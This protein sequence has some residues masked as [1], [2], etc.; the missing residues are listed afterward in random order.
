M[1]A[2]RE[3]HAPL[4]IKSRLLLD[5]T[6][7]NM[8]SPSH[9]RSLSISISNCE[10]LVLPPTTDFILHYPL[11]PSKQVLHLSIAADQPLER[12]EQGWLNLFFVDVLDVKTAAVGRYDKVV[13][14]P[15]GCGEIGIAFC[16]YHMR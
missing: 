7:R 13:S 4:I 12:F 1:R 10:R 14:K 9:R 3:L 8:K 2:P 15:F 11:R 5:A 16:E 6:H